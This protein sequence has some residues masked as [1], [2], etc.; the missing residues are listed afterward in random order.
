MFV[1][2][3]LL[4]LA[5]VLVRMAFG[6]PDLLKWYLVAWALFAAGLWWA[7][8][9]PRRHLT[10][11]VVA[12]GVVLTATGLVAPPSTSSDSYRY[13]WDGRVQAAGLS[14][15]DHAPADPALGHLR[16]G[17]LFPSDC[18]APD[19]ARVS[20]GVCT[21]INRPLV[22]TIYPPL[23]QGYFLL[24]T[25]LAPDGARHLPFQLGGALMAIAVLLALCR[26][27]G[28]RAAAY[29]GW[30]PAVSAEAVSNAHIDMLGVLLVVLAF[31]VLGGRARGAL[32]GAASGALLGA[33]VAAKLLPVITLPGALSGVLRHG[34][35]WRRTLTVVGPAA[36]VVVL[37]YLPYAL[38]SRGSV[39][40]YLF[41]YVQEEGYEAPSARERY[42][43]L[44]LVMPDSW[45]PFA[46]ILIVVLI[47]L[48]V[49]CNGD[50]ARPWAGA[51]LLSGSLLLLLTPEYSWYAL[52]VVPLAAMDGRW[53]WLGVVLASAVSYQFGP[54]TLAYT[55]AALAVLAGWAVRRWRGSHSS[56]S[57]ARM[58]A[59]A[60]AVPRTVP[61]TLER[62]WRRR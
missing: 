32:G 20:E 26:W 45:A 53:E 38:T 42:G 21:R 15:Y 25:W 12:G 5:A 39:L 1:G 44:R 60:R 3:T 9:V 24:V 50:P 17:W 22:H 11:L 46:A 10:V 62:P 30:C 33:A 6:R 31:C 40:G 14:P 37:A 56:L 35:A 57:T 36:L 4:A 61:V 19:R 18:E 59:I 34:V 29:W 13:A 58:S 54:A 51:L 8:R 23:A 55:L 2:A 49:L 28:V 41:G 27:V 7:R 16:D 48:H 47:V 52:L 43:V